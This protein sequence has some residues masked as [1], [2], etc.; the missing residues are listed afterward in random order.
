[1]S[2]PWVKPLNPGVGSGLTAFNPG[3]DPGLNRVSLLDSGLTTFSSSQPKRAAE[4]TG[5]AR[6]RTSAIPTDLD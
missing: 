4:D 1:M 6:S 5:F 3:V 2:N